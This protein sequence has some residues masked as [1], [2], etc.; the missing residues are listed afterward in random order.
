MLRLIKIVF[1]CAL[2]A[3]LL[4][5]AIANRSF[6]T[7]NLLPEGMSPVY[8]FSYD[9][10][11]FVVILASVL[12]GLIIGY[13]LEWLREHKH[14]AARRAKEREVRTLTREVDSMKRKEQKTESDEILALLN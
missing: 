11:L 3:G 4:L 7:L 8:A 10:P 2:M 5:V 6:V 9:L 12:V 14:R 13:I 1:L